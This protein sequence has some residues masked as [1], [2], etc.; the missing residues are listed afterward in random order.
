M[1]FGWIN[2]TTRIECSITNQGL[3]TRTYLIF[4]V[5]NC[6]SLM[7][8]DFVLVTSRYVRMFQI[9]HKNHHVKSKFGYTVIICIIFMCFML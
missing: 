3:I 6:V 5:Q 4:H 2:G 9:L 8:I 1:E 7:L